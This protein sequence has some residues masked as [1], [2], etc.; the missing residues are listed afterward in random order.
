MIDRD[1]D[2]DADGR[3]VWQ[4]AMSLCAVVV[5]DGS[6]LLIHTGTIPAIL[7]KPKGASSVKPVSKQ[8][9]MKTHTS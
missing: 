7:V 4:R 1:R 8:G 3:T 2:A 6:K 5:V 9:E